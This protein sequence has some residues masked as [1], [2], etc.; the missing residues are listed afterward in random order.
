MKKFILISQYFEQFSTFSTQGQ[1]FYFLI[2][3]QVLYKQ[4]INAT[5]KRTK[6]SKTVYASKSVLEYWG[7]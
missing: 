2:C 3:W 7:T 1:I 5:E 6:T 4:F